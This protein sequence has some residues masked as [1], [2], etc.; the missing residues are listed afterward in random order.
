MHQTILRTDR[1]V[2]FMVILMMIAMV[3][4]LISATRRKILRAQPELSTLS[5]MRSISKYSDGSYKEHS[6]EG[7]KVG[8]D[9]D[10]TR[11]SVFKPSFTE[12][13]TL[14][15]DWTVAD[16]TCSIAGSS[17]VMSQPLMYWSDTTPLDSVYETETTTMTDTYLMEMFQTQLASGGNYSRT[18]GVYLSG[19]RPLPSANP[20]NL[21]FQ[22]LI[23][24]EDTMDVDA[25]AIGGTLSGTKIFTWKSSFRG[26]GDI[27]IN[28]IRQVTDQ[29]TVA[30]RINRNTIWVDWM[31]S[32]QNEVYVI[33][34]DPDMM[35]TGKSN[36]L[37]FTK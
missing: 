10:E 9:T 23:E 19:D 26:N 16:V 7:M 5:G 12:T 15:K 4:E 28:D 24:K 14:Y 21:S 2:I 1:I 31:Q 30:N 25:L 17:A 33:V 8:T 13:V 29:F 37:T 27:Y 36:I 32:G 35:S 18:T 3:P 22:V 6:A 20:V 11:M 34:K